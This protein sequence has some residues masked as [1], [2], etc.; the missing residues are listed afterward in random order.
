MISIAICD[1]CYSD[2]KTLMEKITGYFH[3]KGEECVIELHET[4]RTLLESTRKK[5][6]DLLLLDIV[7][8]DMNGI[9][10]AEKIRTVNSGVG[11][12]F[13]SSSREFALEGYS[14]RAFAYLLKPLDENQLYSV[15][16]KYLKQYT[17]ADV[18]VIQVRTEGV[19]VDVPLGKLIYVESNDK[20]LTF[21]M[22]DETQIETYG[23]LD[24]YSVKLSG[25]DN[26]LRCHKSYLINMDYVEGVKGNG[27]LLKNEKVI[28]IPK[29]GASFKKKIYY[30]YVM[31]K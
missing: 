8:G 13:I 26:F 28:P 7:L 25:F 1:D 24:E 18:G 30:D 21:H 3:D 27:F 20:R 14:V 19:N 31:N 6:F 12:V 16:D 4:G 23:K 29:D 10:L 5:E 9:N 15:L 22:S 2:R 17:R 11:I